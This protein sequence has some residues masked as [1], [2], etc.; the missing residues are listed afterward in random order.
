MEVGAIG[1]AFD[2]GA[3]GALDQYLDCA[4]RELQQLQ[5]IGK[6]ADIV[7]RG[8]LRIVVGRIHLGGE[9]NLLLRAHYVFQRLDRFFAANKKRNDHMREH[10]DVAQREDCIDTVTRTAWEFGHLGTFLPRPPLA[11]RE[12]HLS[13]HS[14]LRLLPKG[15][16]WLARKEA[17]DLAC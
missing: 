1:K 16:A 2:L 3:G 12:S 11:D 14:P 9:Q 7:D 4:V 6:R 15:S 8:R 5:H 10:N 17:P 13:G